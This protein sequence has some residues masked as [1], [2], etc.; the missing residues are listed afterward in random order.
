[1]NDFTFY[2]VVLVIL[3]VEESV[4][5]LDHEDSREVQDCGEQQGSLEK[6]ATVVTWE[7]MVYQVLQVI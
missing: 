5:V 1:M 2:R 6:M 7:L 4:V 3:L